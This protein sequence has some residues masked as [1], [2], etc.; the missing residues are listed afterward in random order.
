MKKT[1]LLLISLLLTS[2]VFCQFTMNSS[3]NL[4]PGENYRIDSYIEIPSIDPGASGTNITWDFSTISGGTYIAGESA[5]C[6]DPAGTPFADSAAVAN[7]NLCVRG[8]G[9]S[10]E[11]PFVYHELTNSDQT[12]LGIGNAESGAVSFVNYMDPLTGMEFPCSYGSNFSDNYEYQI[13][14][15]TAGM[16][17]MKDVGTAT[18]TVDAWGSITTP[19]AH[20]D[21][22]IRLVTTT[23]SDMYMNFGAGWVHTI[24]NVDIHYSWM[25]ENLK[26]SVFSIT[27]FVSVGGYNATYLVDHNF[28]VGI[29]EQEELSFNL[30]PNPAGESVNILSEKAM[31]G[32]SIFSMDG[33]ILQS[34]ELNQ[35][36]METSLDLN[37]YPKGLYLVEIRYGNGQVS[38]ERLVKQ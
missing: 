34:R 36:T 23:T 16:Y 15:T 30:F 17:F 26:V 8:E 11:G 37:Q 22:V 7:A 9:T 31:E 20:Y 27:E 6:V 32:V 13:Y 4:V 14:N 29:E 28:P 25:A 33:R 2:A 5:F 21:N 38:H 18:T 10:D 19:E 1:T 35:G 12:M 24:S 3:Y